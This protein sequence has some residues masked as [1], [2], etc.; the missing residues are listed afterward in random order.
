MPKELPNV[1]EN[2]KEAMLRLKRTVVCYD[3]E[4]YVVVAITNHKADGIFRIYLDPLAKTSEQMS[5]GRP[6]PEQ[7]PPEHSGLGAYMDEWMAV[8]P[9]AGIL[10]KQMNSPLFNRFRPYPLGMCNT[11]GGGTYYIERQPNRRTE[12]GLLSAMLQETPINVSPT[13]IPRGRMS[14]DIYGA[15]FKDCVMGKY[16]SAQ[17]CLVNLLDP[18][19]VNEAAA[20]H[21]E[22]ALVR[23]PL[24]MLFLAYKHDIVG[25]L[26]KNDFS[27]VRLGRDHHH[28]K[29]VIENL[30]VFSAILM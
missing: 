8:H 23:G 9:Q 21:R 10:R 12:Q 22:F 6:E 17:E 19:V 7:F 2:V 13:S 29:E 16:P 26:P 4:P 1:Y 15:A 25:V 30:G 5:H 3:G 24:S 20:F 18:E 27:M 28:C 11:K 14:V